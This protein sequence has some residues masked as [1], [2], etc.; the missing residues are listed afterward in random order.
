MSLPA[1]LAFVL[2]DEMRE[3]REG[4]IF[5]FRGKYYLLPV[6]YIKHY[7]DIT[8]LRIKLDELKHVELPNKRPT[9]ISGLV[10]KPDE[11]VKRDYINIGAGVAKRA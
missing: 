3:E 5:L 8:G 10:L 2:K 4:W 11:V 7:S 1:S 9:F 6:E